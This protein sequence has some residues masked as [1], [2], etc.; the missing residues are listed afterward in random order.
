MATQEDQVEKSLNMPVTNP[1]LCGLTTTKILRDE[2]LRLR[3]TLTA[4]Q[5]AAKK[6][7]REDLCDCDS[8]AP[9]DHYGDCRARDLAEAVKESES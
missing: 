7:I 9:P 3:I 1:E 5:E 8:H 6:A 2:V 4:L